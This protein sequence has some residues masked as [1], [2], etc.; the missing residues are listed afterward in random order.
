MVV[1][2]KKILASI[3]LTAI[4]S[5]S[6][7]AQEQPPQPNP[8][9]GPLPPGAPIDDGLII[10]FVTAIVYGVYISLKLSKKTK[11]I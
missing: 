3:L 6:M 7:V 10:L 2:N 5:V 11:Q 9:G 1:N 8:S 4:S